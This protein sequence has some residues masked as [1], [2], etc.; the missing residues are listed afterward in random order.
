MNL[1]K[2]IN[3]LLG[4]LILILILNIIEPVYIGNFI[5]SLDPSEP[6]CYFSNSEEVPLDIC[7]YEIEKQLTCESFE[8]NIKCFTSRTSGKYYIVNQKAFHQCLKE[9]YNVEV[10]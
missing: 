3:I 10:Q 7:C 8:D 1:I 5:Y 2:I 4:V 9:G 6:K